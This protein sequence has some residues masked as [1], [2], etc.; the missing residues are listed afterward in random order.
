[1]WR[2]VT[3]LVAGVVGAGLGVFWL[4]EGLERTDQLA[5]V[6]GAL[7]G[8]A[9]LTL[10]IWSVGQVRAVR[11][12]N[13]APQ[14]RDATPL[15]GGQSVTH[16][17][18]GRDNIQVGQADLRTTHHV[19]DN[20]YADGSI[21]TLLF[22]DIGALKEMLAGPSFEESY[23]VERDL[24]KAIEGF[25]LHVARLPDAEAR[26]RLEFVADGLPRTG[27][28]E[29]FHSGWTR[30]EQVAKDL[31]T[32]ATAVTGAIARGEPLP[33]EPLTIANYRSASD[34]SRAFALRHVGDGSTRRV[35]DDRD[36]PHRWR[37]P[38]PRK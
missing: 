34:E 31:L 4:R 27:Y 17:H 30:R 19:G 16:S 5:S 21:A 32:E 3:L 23:P 28:I 6:V 14:G 7:L 20:Y 24:R 12:L 2:V 26:S 8:L 11:A 36:Q 35:D 38:R 1:M 13:R 15:P 9:S 25:K 29:Q 22:D 18:I 33:Q 10:S 37:G